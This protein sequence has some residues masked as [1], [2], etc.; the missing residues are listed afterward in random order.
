MNRRELLALAAL[1]LTGANA[2]ARMSWAAAALTQPSGALQPVS[3]AER[4]GRI[5]KAQA[6]M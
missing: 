6:L 3:M 4:E 5:A 1:G 2:A